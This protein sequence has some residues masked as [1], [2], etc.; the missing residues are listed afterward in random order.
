MRKICSYLLLVG[1][2]FVS[3]ADTYATTNY[4][5]EPSNVTTQISKYLE[6]INLDNLDESESFMIDF[7][8]NGKGE[9]IVLATNSDNYDNMIKATLNYKRLKEHGLSINKTYTLPITFKSEK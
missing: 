8:L 7:M 3:T 2:L 9:I 1:F 6:T 5:A 4:D